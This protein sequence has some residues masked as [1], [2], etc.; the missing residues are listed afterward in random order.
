MRLICDRYCTPEQK[1][2]SQKVFV[3]FR[4]V[5]PMKSK[6]QKFRKNMNFKK[7]IYPKVLEEHQP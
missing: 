5:E 1:R 2:E 7:Q 6:R 3:G 4:I